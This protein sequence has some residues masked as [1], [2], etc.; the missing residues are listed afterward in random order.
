MAIPLHTTTCPLARPEIGFTAVGNGTRKSSRRVPHDLDRVRGTAPAPC[1]SRSQR[2]WRAHHC[3][4]TTTRQRL[5]TLRFVALGKPLTRGYNG[6]KLAST[7]GFSGFSVETRQPVCEAAGCWFE[8][9]RGYSWRPGTLFRP[10]VSESGR[11]HRWGRWWRLGDSWLPALRM[12]FGWRGERP[13][14]TMVER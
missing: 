6:P 13:G 10:G 1:S 14:T 7:G 8:S 11:A 3:R 5:R 12:G 4:P 2:R 9:K